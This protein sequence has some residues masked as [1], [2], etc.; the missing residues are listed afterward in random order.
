MIFAENGQAA[1]KCESKL[2][3]R[4][5]ELTGRCTGHTQ[6]VHGY[7]RIQVFVAEISAVD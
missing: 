7:E 6:I 3:P 5:I 1:L 2:P 4:E